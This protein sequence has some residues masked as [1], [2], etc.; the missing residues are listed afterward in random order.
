MK[1]ECTEPKPNNSGACPIQELLARLGDKWSVLVIITLAKADQKPLRFSELIRQI[2]GISQRMLTTTLKYLERDGI[3][4]RTQFAEIPPRVE[5]SLTER[6]NELLPPLQS[7][8]AWIE[9]RWPDIQES[10]QS[11]DLRN[12]S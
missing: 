12:N 11:F 3:V 10:R 9:S 7:L 2:Q 1:F 8:V 6:G 5:Y 4:L